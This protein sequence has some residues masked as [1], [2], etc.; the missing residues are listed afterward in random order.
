MDSA[1]QVIAAVHVA[2]E[3]ND[4]QELLPMIEQTEQNFSDAIHECNAD[5]GY[6]SGEDLNL[7]ALGLRKIDFYISDLGYQTNSTASL[8][9]FFTRTASF[10]LAER[11]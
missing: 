1:H 8:F 5:V 7:N 6:R 3:A 4:V 10:M 11:L 9:K 2:T